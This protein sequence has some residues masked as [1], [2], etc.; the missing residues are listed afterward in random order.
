MVFP[1]GLIDNKSVLVQRV[2]WSRIGNESLSEPIL[3][4]C[5]GIY[6]F[7]LE[8]LIQYENCS[9]ENNKNQL[10]SSCDF[11][12]MNNDVVH[13]YATKKT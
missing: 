13:V 1:R 12:G 11:G 9:K 8:E 5:T 3:A 4:W 6:V 2:A 7:G 10:P